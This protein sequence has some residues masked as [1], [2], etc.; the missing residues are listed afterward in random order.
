MLGRSCYQSLGRRLVE[1]SRVEWR[2]ER[3]EEGKGDRERGGEGRGGRFTDHCEV[4][5]LPWEVSPLEVSAWT[6]DMIWKFEKDDS[7]HF[8]EDRICP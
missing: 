8:R 6:D 7:C 3:N 4:L 2:A 1:W 5:T